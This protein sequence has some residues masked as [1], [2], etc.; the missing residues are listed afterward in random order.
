MALN[1]SLARN[2]EE[3]KG[4]PHDLVLEDGDSLHIPE[5]SAQIQVIGAV[6][7]QNAFVYTKKGSI[8]R[9]INLAGGFT[10]D[11]NKKEV[12]VLKVDGTAISERGTRGFGRL[13]LDP[14]D[15]IVVPEKLDKIAW[16]RNL[17]DITQILYQL[18]ITAAVLITL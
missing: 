10:K 14:G 13:G 7:N 12:Y 15:T 18:A 8:E 17:K 5:R 1:L 16:M 4:S 6:Y 11:A 3:F 2:I 9:Y